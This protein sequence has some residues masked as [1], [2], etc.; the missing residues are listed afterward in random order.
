M[1]ARSWI[2][3]ALLALVGCGKTQAPESSGASSSTGTVETPVKKIELPASLMHEGLEYYGLSEPGKHTMTETRK[4]G[5][6]TQTLVGDMTT[7]LVDAT[8]DKATYEMEFDGDLSALGTT[9]IMVD[10][11][12]VHIVTSS[13]VKTDKPTLDLPAVC[14]V[15]ATWAS[16]MSGEMATQKVKGNSTYKIVRTE[17][18]KVPAGEFDAI[19]VENVGTLSLGGSKFPLKATAWY[20]KGK[21]MVR[22]VTE[23]TQAG[24]K[25]VSTLELTK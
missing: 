2:P 22:Q 10:K 21:G 3:L 23:A 4:T 24:Q 16:D 6:Q 20:V 14:S 13:T 12:G 5:D 19:V 11:G 8:A 25:M 15:G 9:T 17:K 7:R 1:Q 18:V